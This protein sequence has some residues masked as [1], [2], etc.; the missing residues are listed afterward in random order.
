MQLWGEPAGKSDLREK[1]IC[2]F[3]EF[4]YFGAR[5]AE[6]YSQFEKNASR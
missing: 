3:V 1:V 5:E 2:N 6:G 4:F